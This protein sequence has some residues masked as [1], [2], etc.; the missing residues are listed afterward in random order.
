MELFLSWAPPIIRYVE[1]FFRI[2]SYFYPPKSDGA[3]IIRYGNIKRDITKSKIRNSR[4]YPGCHFLESKPPTS[5]AILYHKLNNGSPFTIR[6]CL[7]CLYCCSRAD[8]PPFTCIVEDFSAISLVHYRL[9]FSGSWCNV[10]FF[11]KYRCTRT[12]VSFF[13]KQQIIYNMEGK[14]TLPTYT[15][16][17]DVTRLVSVIVWY[18][19]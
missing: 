13:H 9:A 12:D 4:P 7:L 18:K 15:E 10:C 19:K 6:D 2:W 16:P 11:I 5:W 1:L 3:P 14:K 17:L 8:K